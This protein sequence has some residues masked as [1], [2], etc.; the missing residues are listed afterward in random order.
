MPAGSDELMRMVEV[1]GALASYAY[2]KGSHD[3]IPAVRHI[4]SISCGH[5]S[6]SIYQ[7]SGWTVIAI[8]GTDERADWG[9]SCEREFVPSENGIR[10]HAGFLKFA[11]V[12]SMALRSEQQNLKCEDCRLL[13]TGHSLGGAAATI[14]PLVSDL[15]PH[16]VITF[17]APKCM[18]GEDTHMYA[19]RVINVRNLDDIIP[20]IPLAKVNR[21]WGSPGE[22]YYLTGSAVSSFPGSPLR[23]FAKQAY[24]AAT[25]FMRRGKFLGIYDHGMPR[26]LKNISGVRNR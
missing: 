8:T 9:Y 16:S 2:L 23:R 6:F 19:H 24:S 17:G 4:K 21:P 26:Y 10:V 12:I 15:N 3:P 25:Y 5:V 14:L 1:C 7:S 13:I 11:E 22:V 20:W 18:H